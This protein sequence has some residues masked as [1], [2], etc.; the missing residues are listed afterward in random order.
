MEYPVYADSH[1]NSG[2]PVDGARIRISVPFTGDR[3]LFSLQPSAFTAKRPRGIVE[4]Q[5]LYV[6]FYSPVNSLNSDYKMHIENQLD[7]VRSHVQGINED[8]RQFD[9]RLRMEVRQY[10]LS[11]RTNLEK[12]EEFTSGFPISM[13]KRKDAPEI[14]LVRKNIRPLPA[15]KESPREPFLLEEVYDHILRVIRHAGCSFEA[16]AKTFAKFEEEELRDVVLAHLNGHYEGGAS[17]EAF[18]K[19]GKTD[20]LIEFENRSAFVGECKVW[21]GPAQTA[22]ALKQ[23]LGYVT[24]RDTRSSL[25]VFNKTR[26]G[27]SN[28]Q[29]KLVESLQAHANFKRQMTCNFSDEWRM[30]FSSA[31]DPECLVTIHVF[32]FDLFVRPI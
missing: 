12:I 23:L 27:F 20:I 3:N 11:R 8:L 25:I 31:E 28:I 26:S 2:E 9:E 6:Y 32:C 13:R 22:D 21:A 7:S 24:R 19:T 14:S 1:E 30:E 10:V 15:P 4:E 16:T 17:A 29:R 5:V 18:R